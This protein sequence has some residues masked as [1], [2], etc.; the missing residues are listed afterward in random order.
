MCEDGHKTLNWYVVRLAICIYPSFKMSGIAYALF[1]L[2]I[3]SVSKHTI[4]LSAILLLCLLPCILCLLYHPYLHVS[5]ADQLGLI[6][7]GANPPA[8]GLHEFS[9]LSNIQNLSS[10]QTPA[11]KNV[12]FALNPFEGELRYTSSSGLD[13]ISYPV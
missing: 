13:G 4:K 2:P 6:K 1:S 12:C 10:T 8:H 9:L 7:L 3:L 11:H 5:I